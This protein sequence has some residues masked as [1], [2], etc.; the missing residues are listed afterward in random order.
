MCQKPLGLEDGTIPNA[1][2]TASTVYGPGKESWRGRLNNFPSKLYDRRRDVGTWIARDLK[3][4]EYLQIDLGRRTAVTMVA[5][6]GRPKDYAHFLTEYT[7]QYS[8]DG[9]VW[10]FCT[11]NNVTKVCSH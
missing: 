9:K 10:D 1:A 7:I 6:Q 5:T 8:T 3:Q 4:G 11:E 2:I